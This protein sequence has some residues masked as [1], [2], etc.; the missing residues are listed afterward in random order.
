M[1]EVLGSSGNDLTI[2][3]PS[4]GD[5]DWATSIRNNCFQ[6]ISDHKHEASGDGAKIRGYLGISWTDALLPNDTDVLA[7]NNAGTGTVTLF[8]VNTSDEFVADDIVFNFDDDVFTLRDQADTTKKVNFQLSGITTGT[9]RTW[10][11][12]DAADT[13]VGTT[14]TQTL[15]NKTFTSPTITG[16]V[17][18]LPQI[19]DTSDDHQYVFAVSELAADRTVTLPL[20]TG[21]DEFVFKDHSVTLTNK[22][23]TSAVLN[24]SVSGTAILDE[25]NMASDS[26]TQLATQ[27]SIKAYVDANAGGDLTVAGDS[28]SDTVTVGTDTLTIA[29][30][31]NEI[32]TSVA[33]DTA[34]LGIADNPVLPGTEG[35]VLPSGTTAQRPGSP[36]AGEIRYNTTDG[37]F[38]GYTDSWGELGGG[39]A[40]ES[41]IKLY[42][43]FSDSD[44]DF[45]A[46]SID[47]ILPDFDGTDTLTATF[48]VPSSGSDALLSNDDANKVYRYASA[49][50]SQYDAVGFNVNIPKYIRGRDVL[51]QFEYRTEDTSGSSVNGDYM[52]WV[53]DQ[54]NG[55]NTTTTTTGSQAAG[56]TLTVGTTTGMSVG[57]KIWVGE[58]GGTDQVTEAHITEVPSGTTL[59]ISEDV[60]LS[61]GD[62]FVTGILTDV[63]TTLDA[64]DSDTDKEG[65]TFKVNF[66][67]ATDTAQVTVMWQQLTAETDSELFFDNILISSDPFKQIATKGVPEEYRTSDAQGYG[68]TNTRIPYFKTTPDKNTIDR[69]GSITNDSTNGF[70]FTATKPCK[71][72]LSHTSNET[73]SDL[74]MG[75]SLNSSQLTTSILSINEED[76]LAIGYS[77]GSGQPSSCSATVVLSPGDVIRPHNGNVG[78]LHSTDQ[79]HSLVLVAEPLENQSVVVESTDSVLTTWTSYTPTIQGFGTIAS[80]DFVYRRVGDSM[81]IQGQFVGG[82]IAASEIQIGLPDSKQIDTDIST[83]HIVG[84]LV[85][86]GGGTVIGSVLATAGDTYLNV[87]N[88]G[89]SVALT[90]QNGNSLF[91]S[92]RTFSLFARVPIAGWDAAPKP[93][94]AFPTITTGQEP[95]YAHF[96]NIAGMSSGNTHVPYYTSVR[97]NTFNTLA[98]LDPTDSTNGAILTAQKR[99]KVTVSGS[100][101]DSNTGDVGVT[102]NPTSGEMDASISSIYTKL[103][104]FGYSLSTAQA[105]F[106]GETILEPGDTLVVHI[107]DTTNTRTGDNRDYISIVAEPIH[108]Q[109]NQAAIISQPVAF[110]K[111]VEAAGTN[112]GT[113]TSGS[114]EKISVNTLSGDIAD[115]GVSLSSGVITL[116][117]GKFLIEGHVPIFDT[118]TGKSRLRNT[119]DSTTAIVGESTYAN[120][121]A[122]S[123]ANAMVSGVLT[124]TESKNFELQAQVGTTSTSTNGYGVACNFGEVEVYSTLKITRLK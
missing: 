123:A 51:L 82:T 93:L 70:A 95:E 5:T 47:D 26:A 101:Y 71:V 37:K 109:T 72:H 19:N 96:Y 114:W 99:I 54:T 60:N 33:S 7:R 117:A 8:K 31:S 49:T 58:T 11:F 118:N 45:T 38:E 2:T 17:L 106:S 43:A 53:F 100:I 94:L 9:T 69:L 29:G 84:T 15:T 68:S 22:T 57:D 48:E 107:S 39:V 121:S 110:V 10:T 20:L 92:S 34:T 79:Y 30:T 120:P 3:I 103:V 85:E 81:E 67:P 119:S 83:V 80:S 14:A 113:A 77:P 66:K 28:G 24:T 86:D 64:A 35:A 25:D 104:A 50:G 75:I 44:T 46:K 12:P 97:D 63:L 116:P 89:S 55:V 91:G 115:V 23:L 111:Q 16:P 102:K 78:T 105:T 56:S 40:G 61:S 27:Q 1:S 88:Q 73:G 124:L 4:S 112:G 42:R 98:T 87:G 90:P 52:V 59:K 32:T 41:V 62:R 18:D 21:D 36:T 74:Y 13:F 122:T 108:G 76:I 65:T 6:V